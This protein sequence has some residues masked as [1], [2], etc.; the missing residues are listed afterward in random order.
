MVERYSDS[1]IIVAHI[2]WAHTQLALASALEAG[3]RYRQILLARPIVPLSNRDLGFLPGDVDAK[4]DPCMQPLYDNLT[5]LRHE[6][7]GLKEE[8]KEMMED[9]R[10][11]IAPLAC[12]CCHRYATE[13]CH[14]KN[15]ASGSWKV[16]FQQ[17]ASEWIF[18][19]HSL[20]LRAGSGKLFR[21]RSLRRKG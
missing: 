15:Y 10:I 19:D 20:A 9:K 11:E 13:V 3:N 14:F 16:I 17:A 6:N 2:H 12:M 5:V 7:P 21:T 8:L 1:T 18:G 4:L